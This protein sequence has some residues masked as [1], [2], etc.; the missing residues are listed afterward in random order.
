MFRNLLI[1]LGVNVRPEYCCGK[2]PAIVGGGYDCT[3]KD[4]PRCKKFSA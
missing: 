3:C 1:K 2:C 4:N